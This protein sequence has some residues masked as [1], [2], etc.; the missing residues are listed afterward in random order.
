MEPVVTPAV[1]IQ[2]E[3]TLVEKPNSTHKSYITYYQTKLYYVIDEFINLNTMS[4][5]K[6]EK[7]LKVVDETDFYYR[8]LRK[9]AH[10]ARGV[11]GKNPEYLKKRQ[12]FIR[13]LAT[14]RTPDKL[15]TITTDSRT[16]EDR[17]IDAYVFG[18]KL[19]YDFARQYLPII[20]DHHSTNMIDA[21]TTPFP[22]PNVDIR[23]N[24]AKAIKFKEDI[25][26]YQKQT[27]DPLIM[28][29]FILPWFHEKVK[30]GAEWDFKKDY[31]IKPDVRQVVHPAM[32]EAQL[33]YQNFGNYHYGIIGAALGISEEM[34]L[35]AA[36]FAQHMAG[37]NKPEWGHYLVGPAPYGDQPEDQEFIKRGIED[38]KSGKFALSQ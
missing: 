11:L 21:G 30:N 36:G 4:D 15:G 1:R 26:E 17:E 13:N 6:Y 5:D 25:L 32:I 20:K 34:L 2:G 28:K 14:T 23:H 16:P 22:P 10:Y 3:D 38:Y 8:N 19:S 12:D 9:E 37:T 33:N 18:Y 31:K 35:Q 29:T 7:Y 24:L 27:R